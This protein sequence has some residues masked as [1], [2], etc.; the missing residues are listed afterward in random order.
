M[1]TDLST[2]NPVWRALVR[3]RLAAD[4]TEP[5]KLL[6]IGYLSYMLIGFALLS[7]P[8]AQ[9]TPVAALD[10]LFIATSAVSTTGLVTVDPGTSFT[11]FGELV[12]LLLIQIGGL[13]YMTIGS[14][15]VLALQDNLGKMRARTC[16][17]AFNLPEDIS[18]KLF[19]R[20]VVIF[21][22]IC[23]AIGAAILYPKFAAAG[24]DNPLWAA[25]F[26]AV[27]AFCTA[28]FSLFS[29]SLEAFRGDFTVNATISALS[30]FGAMGFL[31]IVDLWRTLMGRQ[32]NLGFT[33]KVIFRLTM[34][35]LILGTAVVMVTDPGIIALPAEERIM[36]AFFQVMTA[37]TTVG[38]NTYPISELS[39]AVLLVVMFLMVIGAS[40]AGTGGGL[41]TTSFAVLIGLVRSTL[42]GRDE[43]RFFKRRVRFEQ[44][45]TATASLVFYLGLMVA[46]LFCLLLTEPALDFAALLF[47]ALS[48]MGTV[49]LSMGATGELSPLGKVVIIVLMTAGRVGILTFGIALASRDES[50]EEER[51]NELVM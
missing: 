9:A 24:V 26:H 19:L 22:L 17:A 3:L 48:A 20:S 7:L 35:F 28:G 13:G 29:S 16:R 8:F 37:A 4:N 42:K 49:G 27:S 21:T 39:M 18:P 11:F 44:L 36:T 34:L 10:A 47:E 30:I 51:D 31:I 45:Q 14:F 5:A 40:P 6:L 41:K 43:V 25:I 46:A 38:F 2:H 32:R 15:A 33:S 50:R 1:K 12:V 23:E